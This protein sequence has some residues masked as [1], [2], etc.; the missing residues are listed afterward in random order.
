MFAVVCYIEAFNMNTSPKSST[1]RSSSTSTAHREKKVTNKTTLT[2]EN[3]CAR[4]SVVGEKSAV[5]QATATP[6]RSINAKGF[7]RK[8]DG[9]DDARALGSALAKKAVA[10][11]A[12]K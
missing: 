8:V 1:K 2:F 10:M 5:V 3:L 4:S 7:L 9:F 6:F 12:H 11:I